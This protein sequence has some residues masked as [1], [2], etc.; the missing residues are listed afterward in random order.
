VTSLI[1][2]EHASLGYGRRVV[3][4]DISFEVNPGDYLGL[5]GP[6]GAGKTTVLKALLGI[7]RPIAG[8]LR[9]QP[10][11]RFGYVPQREQ[12]NYNFPLSV[13]DV[14]L[15]GRT[16]NGRWERAARARDRA[17]VDRALEQ[18]G[19]TALARRQIRSLSGGERQRMLIARALASEPTMLVLDEPTNGMD[20][21]A[22]TQILALVRQLRRDRGMTVLLVSHALNEV[23]N[24]VDHIALVVGGRFRLGTT[25]EIL[26]S[27]TLTG[28]YGIPVEVA[29]FGG[30]HVVMAQPGPAALEAAARDPRRGIGR[31]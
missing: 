11:L 2:F 25:L 24:E 31:A 17:A 29:H 7:H 21:G 13:A 28:M 6:N 3:L 23:A 15:M 1:A 12:L 5:V 18:V 9:R 22:T 8:L 14:V 26:T 4:E 19:L 27:D 16:P 20:L 30:R 10:G